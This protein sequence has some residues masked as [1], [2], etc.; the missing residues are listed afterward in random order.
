MACGCLGFQ[1]GNLAK[2]LQDFHRLPATG[3]RSALSQ[4]MC[5]SCPH[6][7]ATHLH[8]EQRQSGFDCIFELISSCDV[9]EHQLTHELLQLSV[10]PNGTL[11]LVGIA[12]SHQGQPRLLVRWCYLTA[13]NDAGICEQSDLEDLSIANSK[14][15]SN[16]DKPVVEHSTDSSFGDPPNECAKGRSRK[17]KNEQMQP[18]NVRRSARLTAQNSACVPDAMQSSMDLIRKEREA[19]RVRTAFVKNSVEECFKHTAEP[20]LLDLSEVS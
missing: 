9:S 18:G 7:L 16:A 10:S 4:L 17:R 11:V 2:T 8:Q 19:E 3:V 15:G 20:N 14:G 5:T 1:V 12:N 13:G 6:T